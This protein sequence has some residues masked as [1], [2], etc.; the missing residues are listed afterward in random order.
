MATVLITGASGFVGSHTL[1]ALTAAGHQVRALVRDARGAELVR[2]R[3]APA[4]V[5]RV[6]IVV[7][8]VNQPQTL[9]PALA[10]VDAVVH[11]VALPRDN[12]GG[13]DLER[14]NTK[15]TRNVIAAMAA[16]GVERLVHLGAMGVVDD[17]NLHYAGSKARAEAAVRTSTSR[18]TILKPSLLWGERDGFFNIV[19]GLVRTSPG[20]VPVPG[21]RL[22]KFQPLSVEDL[23]RAV[24][25]CLERDET[26]GRSYDLGG[27]DYW[28]YRQMVAE[29]ITAMGKRR[30]IV[31]MP[32]PLIKV[33][34]RTSEMLHLPFPVASDQLRQL[35]FDNAAG[36]GDVERDFGF[37][38]RSMKGSL[39]YLRQGRKGQE[40]SPLGGSASA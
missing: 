24:V 9:S 34:A 15:G 10:G 31:T 7:G 2:A 3:L 1:P 6:T 19:A 20:I 23:A 40:P 30:R 4:Q 35:A 38:P 5:S 13:A 32:L 22:S 12:S 25:S 27:P 39:G 29:V 36:L 33:V 21:G 16:A 28:T 11:L 17:P 37:A 14:V 26:I 8:D 18:W